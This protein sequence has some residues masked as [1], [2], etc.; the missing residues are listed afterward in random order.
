MGRRFRIDVALHVCLFILSVVSGATSGTFI[1]GLAA[2]WVYPSITTIATITATYSIGYTYY[3]AYWSYPLSLKALVLSALF[4]C[5][6]LILPWIWMPYAVYEVALTIGWTPLAKTSLVFCTLSIVVLNF[7]PLTAYAYYRSGTIRLDQDESHGQ[8]PHALYSYSDAVIRWPRNLV[9][10][11]FSWWQQNDIYSHQ[12]VVAEFEDRSSLAIRRSMRI[13]REK[14]NWIPRRGILETYFRTS[15]TKADLTVDSF[16]VAVCTVDPACTQRD[17]HTPE[18]IERSI[19]KI[20]EFSSSY[21]FLAFNCWWFAGCPFFCIAHFIGPS[22]L[23]IRCSREV[24]HSLDDSTFEEAMAFCEA[25]Y[26]RSHWP[27]WILVSPPMI[28]I[29][30]SL[31][32]ITNWC[33]LGYT[34]PP[35]LVLAWL[36]YYIIIIAGT[37]RVVREI[38]GSRGINADSGVGIRLAWRAMGVVVVLMC[39]GGLFFAL[40]SIPSLAISEEA[41]TVQN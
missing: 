2:R 13:E 19:D 30:G 24:D 18:L 5:L 4:W 22:N 7:I 10:S 20:N 38:V 8:L 21:S 41:K 9:L 36:M 27:Y 11:R 15:S 37:W 39:Y 34:I 31:S 40:A 14:S 17:Q 16:C 12:F 28:T 23:T 6:V 3:Y 1:H 26:L 25:Y 29:A 33:F 32:L 35:A